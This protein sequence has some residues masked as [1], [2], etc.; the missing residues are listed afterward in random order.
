MNIKVHDDF[1]ATTNNQYQQE[2]LIEM[3][4]HLDVPE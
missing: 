1:L 4:Y 2:T 3:N